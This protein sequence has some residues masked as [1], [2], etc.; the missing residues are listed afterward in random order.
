VREWGELTACDVAY[1][2][3]GDVVL[4]EISGRESLAVC[5]G[6]EACGPGT[7]GLEF[8]PMTAARAA[9]RV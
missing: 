3:R 2:Q 1:A 8:V 5:A 6:A 7:A 9:W 4:V